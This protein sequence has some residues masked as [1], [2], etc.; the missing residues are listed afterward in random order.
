ME[1]F[2]VG[3]EQTDTVY[4]VVSQAVLLPPVAMELLRHQ[5]I[6][7]KLCQTF[8]SSRLAGPTSN[9]SQNINKNI[10]IKSWKEIS[11]N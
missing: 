1:T 9:W 10:Q 5:K 2:S 3:F 11:T 7:L 4:K 8:I 6:C